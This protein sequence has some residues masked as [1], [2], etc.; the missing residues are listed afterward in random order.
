MTSIKSNISTLWPNTAW[1]ASR[2]LESESCN[3]SSHYHYI[4][5]IL[6][7]PI[8][9]VFQVFRQILPPFLPWLCCFC[10]LTW[11]IHSSTLAPASNNMLR[12]VKLLKS[13]G[14]FS[15]IFKA[16]KSLLFGESTSFFTLVTKSKYFT[17][18]K[19]KLKV[20]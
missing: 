20:L 13:F 1:G 6:F 18:C 3:H 8:T 5:T 17:I 15:N 10:W 9:S 7:H 11:I 2:L 4:A 14:Q 12:M 16:V 19:L